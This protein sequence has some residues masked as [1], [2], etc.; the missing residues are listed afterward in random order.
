[1]FPIGTGKSVL[2][3]EIIH[4]FADREPRCLAI[5]AS[6]GIAS[7]NIGG[8]TLHSWAGIGLGEE[9]TKNLV[10]K[11]FGQEKYRNVLDRWRHVKALIID[12]GPLFGMPPSYLLFTSSQ[13]P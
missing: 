1:M 6:T 13:S 5:T 7:V 9:S 2:L 8:T 3:R 10:G 11:F 4:L 12:E